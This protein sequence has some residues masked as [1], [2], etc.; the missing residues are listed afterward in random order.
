MKILHISDTHGTFPLLQL[1]GVDLIVHSGNLFPNL[2]RGN[3]PVEEAFQEEWIAS[4]RTH[5]RAWV[6]G[7][8][9]FFCTGNHDFLS[10]PETF[11]RAVGVE[12]TCLDSML[13]ESFQGVSFQGFPYTPYLQG[14]WNGELQPL[15]MTY[16][17][18]QLLDSWDT[19]VPDV[20]VAHAPLYGHLDQ[21]HEGEHCG[22]HEL[23]VGLQERRD[24]PLPRWMLHGHIH[25]EGGRRSVFQPN[26]P[27]PM[28]ISNA[29]CTQRV[30]HL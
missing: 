18:Q 17:V 5:L 30:I 13:P 11:L 3:V 23:L 9:F 21:N 28:D 29:A 7:R 8:P 12:A 27:Y 15:A 14:E 6:D 10:T 2:T 1:Q 16:M 20:L 24:Q 22:N 19:A 26:S 25:E 4:H